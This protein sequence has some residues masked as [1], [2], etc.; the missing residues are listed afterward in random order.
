MTILLHNDDFASRL[1]LFRLIHRKKEYVTTEKNVCTLQVE[2]K[3]KAYL[4]AI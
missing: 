1:Y 3:L 2:K 4:L